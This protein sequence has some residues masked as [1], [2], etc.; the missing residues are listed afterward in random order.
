MNYS[1]CKQVQ[2]DRVNS[3]Y[4]PSPLR[5]LLDNN[6]K[7][8]QVFEKDRV[9]DTIIGL[10]Y[11]IN[12]YQSVLRNQSSWSILIEEMVCDLSS[13]ISVSDIITVTV[14]NNPDCILGNLARYDDCI[15]SIAVNGI[16]KDVSENTGFNATMALIVMIS[17]IDDGC[18]PNIDKILS[19]YN[20]HNLE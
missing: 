15:A 18:M 19:A 13:N 1:T 17:K 10:R 20:L 11:K 2:L 7:T 12:A 16:K 4:A 3:C 5:T 8:N 9:H 6:F 14:A